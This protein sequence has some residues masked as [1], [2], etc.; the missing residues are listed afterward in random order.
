MSTEY[1]D[2][3]GDLVDAR[4]RYEVN[5]VHYLWA[6]SPATVAPGETTHL[7]VW[8]QSCWDVP[9]EVR[10]RVQLP[11][12]PPSAFK[13]IQERTDVPLEAAEVGEVAIPIACAAITPHGDYPITVGL[14][15]KLEN[16]GL[17]IR[18]KEH[19]GHL[20]KTSLRFASGMSL[21]TSVGI[22]YVARAQ[23]G[24]ALTLHVQGTPQ[25]GAAPELIPTYLSHWTVD[26]LSLLGKARQHVNDRRLYILPQITRHALY[27]NFLEE[28]RHRFQDAGLSLHLGEAVFL[29]K[30]LT[31][32][33]EHFMQHTD[34]QD[35][36]LLPAYTLAFR[37][38]LQT[39]DPVALIVRV[40][41]ARMAL[42]AMS[43]SFGLL[44]QQVG[45]DPWTMEEQLAVTDLVADRVERG[46]SLSAEFLY[47]PLLLGGLM[48]ASEVQMPGEDLNES[49]ALFAS[50][51]QKRAAELEHN[52]ELVALLDRLEQHRGDLRLMFPAIQP[53]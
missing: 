9:A 29:A 37:H 8:L 7:R 20:G 51:R 12:Q 31:A 39:D 17:Y 3:L 46:G 10:I 43:L 28:S 48:V 41:Y 23:A 6:L 33:V 26:E 16:R 50:A 44:R 13:V 2:V 21:A 49:L 11:A 45:R 15:A 36:I 42:L 24:S 30:I 40:D 22:G 1:P 35:A 27:L 19:E 53:N 47:L 52:P 5:G 25:P 14:S 32:T 4:E 18:S 38:D 34:L